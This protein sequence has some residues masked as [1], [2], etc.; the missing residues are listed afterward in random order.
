MSGIS[1]RARFEVRECRHFGKGRCRISKCRY[2][3]RSD[4][5]RLGGLP[6]HVPAC[7]LEIADTHP[8]GMPMELVGQL[9]G[10]TR[11]RIEQIERKAIAKLAQAPEV[12]DALRV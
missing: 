6:R 4:W 3:L 1:L 10:V 8:E 7:A 11:Q 9:V 12:S 5:E 2:S